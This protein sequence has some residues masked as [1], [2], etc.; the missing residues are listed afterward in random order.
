MAVVV[1]FPIYDLY[2]RVPHDTRVTTREDWTALKPVNYWEQAKVQTFASPNGPFRGTF[3]RGVET[4]L[5]L[6]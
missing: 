1:R 2:A 4:L 3:P 6:S 5:D